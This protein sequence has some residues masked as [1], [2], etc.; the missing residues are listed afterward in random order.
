MNILRG[1]RDYRLNQHQHQHFHFVVN[2]YLRISP[3]FLVPAAPPLMEKI[4]CLSETLQHFLISQSVTDRFYQVVFPAP[5]PDQSM[6]NHFYQAVF[7]RLYTR[8]HRPRLPGPGAAGSYPGISPQH[9]AAGF[10][11]P[12]PVFTGLRH[13]GHVDHYREPGHTFEKRKREIIPGPPASGS[14][15]EHLTLRTFTQSSKTANMFIK[16]NRELLKKIRTAAN[17]YYISRERHTQTLMVKKT[18]SL[19]KPVGDLLFTRN[20]ES[21][22]P[23]TTASYPPRPVFKGNSH[24]SHIHGLAGEA[25]PAAGAE[26]ETD[27]SKF[28][29]VSPTL[30]TLMLIDTNPVFT[31]ETRLTTEMS[32]PAVI[33]QSLT[34]PVISNI[35]R[36]HTSSPGDIHG[37]SPTV[38]VPD[39]YYSG[40]MSGVGSN[41]EE[42]RTVTGV[43]KGVKSLEQAAPPPVKF[44]G[45]DQPGDSK[46]TALDLDRLTDQVF[47]KLERKIIIEKE[48]RG[49]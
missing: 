16:E 37:F 5:A 4:R 48:R 28:P 39:L 14:Q 10:Y 49:W 47:K 43:V 2:L 45:Q 13:A 35:T 11:P 12:P 44:F 1:N 24:M 33:Q 32:H 22:Q 6:N 18:N 36:K 25:K 46:K 31:R 38:P 3:H 30:N 7:P 9:A 20:F 19:I 42:S 21:S 41:L 29:G 27:N 34:S 26:L 17:R 8:D 40:P 15:Y 23:G